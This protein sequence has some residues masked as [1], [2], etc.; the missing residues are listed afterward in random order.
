MVRI[1]KPHLTIIVALA[2]LPAMVLLVRP[3]SAAAQYMQQNGHALDNNLQVGSGGQNGAGRPY[4]NS[5]LNQNIATGN[6]SGLNFFH[7]RVATFDPNVIS[8]RDLGDPADRLNAIAAPVNLLQRTTGMPNYTTFYDAQTYTSQ[9]GQPQPNFVVQPG[10][11]GMVP[12]PTIDPLTPSTDV[13]LENNTNQNLGN[14]PLPGELNWAGPVDPTGAASLYSMSPLYG[15]RQIDNTQPMT[16]TAD[17]FFQSRETSTLS[18]ASS[19]DQ[20]KPS[21]MQVLQMRQELNNTALT[22][23]GAEVTPNP[24]A[25]QANPNAPGAAQ[26]NPN[27][28]GAALANPNALGANNLAASSQLNSASMTSQLPTQNL[29]SSL[30]TGAAAAGN[31]STGESMQKRLLVPANKQSK[32]L[33]AL[34]DKYAKMNRKLTDVEASE[35]YNEELRASKTLDNSSVKKSV[36][37]ATPGSELPGGLPQ[38]AAHE[39]NPTT[40]PAVKPI[41]IPSDSAADNQ[42]YVITSLATGIQ[43]RGLA[44]LMKSAEE[45]MRDGKFTEAVD[46]Y[47]TAL[48]VAPN[49]P[50]AALGRSF[51]ELGASYYGKADLDLTRAIRADPAVLAGKYDLNGFLGEDRVKFVTK[52]L[53]D[54]ASHEKGAR[55]LVLLGFISHNLGDDAAA[56]KYLDQAAGRGGYDSLIALMRS[57]WGLKAAGK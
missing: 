18:S 17:T 55:P 57:A 45:K 19:A 42:P 48:A 32:Q 3:R 21:L 1:R 35:K 22:D 51:A 36:S 12:A 44:N 53:A 9:P 14:L 25:P 47:E 7:G 31:F 50:F 5:N 56:A 28:P 11:V 2:G 20:P 27:E 6:V 37:P 13:R 41:L 33:Q 26:P 34:E 46:T 8:G 4:A 23:N 39:G 16:E 38:G 43:A 29:N 24:A 30:P 15:V 49:N 52:D 40:K 10:N 54:I